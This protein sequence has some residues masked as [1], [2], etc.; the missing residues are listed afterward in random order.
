MSGLVSL[1]R[2]AVGGVADKVRDS[3]RMQRASQFVSEKAQA[4]RESERVQGGIEAVKKRAS[5]IAESERVQKGLEAVKEKTEQV[6]EKAKEGVAAT[7]EK[8]AQGLEFAKDKTRALKEGAGSVWERGAGSVSRVRASVKSGAWRGSARDTLDIAAQAEQWKEIKVNGAEELPVPARTEHTCCYHVSKGSTLR[9]TFRVKDN[10]IGFGV[11]MRVQD[12]GGAREEEVLA[13]ERYDNQDT[14]SGSWVADENRTMVLVF[15]NRYSKLRSKTVAYIVG[16][17]KP[18]AFMGLPASEDA[19]S[20]A[21]APAAVDASAAASSATAAAPSSQAPAMPGSGGYESGASAPAAAPVAAQQAG[22]GYGAGAAP[23]AAP[24][25]VA[26]LPPPTSE[27]VEQKE[28]EKER[29][30]V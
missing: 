1:G 18:S 5:E 25:P 6:K 27:A 12:F 28:P 19:A 23:A 13:V 2:M 15:D 21:P 17:E 10:D 7:K 22:G 9:W 20:S 3:E 8:A 29:A 30:L 16:T 11:R 24:A 26:T 14:V 4:V